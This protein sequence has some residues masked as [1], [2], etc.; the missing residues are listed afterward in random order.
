MAKHQYICIRSCVWHKP[1]FATPRYLE[2]DGGKTV[3][4]L[5]DGA[6]LHI[7]RRM[8][9]PLPAA[10][11]AAQVSPEALGMAMRSPKVMF[12]ELSTKDREELEKI[13]RM[14]ELE[15]TS[16]YPDQLSLVKAIMRQAGYIEGSTPATPQQPASS[17][18]ADLVLGTAE[19]EKELAREGQPIPAEKPDDEE[20]DMAQEIQERAK[21]PKPELPAEAVELLNKS[22]KELVEMAEGLGIED[23]GKLGNKQALVEAIL[24]REGAGA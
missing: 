3:Y 16:Q 14:V 17:S 18:T 20:L 24:K 22:R 8:D 2:P 15:D 23:A 5:E 7:F 12:L 1:D 4:L 19:A 9:L 11:P 10:Q 6:P 13:A 21:E